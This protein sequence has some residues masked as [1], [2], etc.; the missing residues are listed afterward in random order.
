MTTESAFSTFC[1]A[2]K[3]KNLA[4]M[5]KTVGEIAKKLNEKYYNV[6]GDTSS[7]G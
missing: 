7:H 3:L 1:E 6:K 4:E 2:I 5:E